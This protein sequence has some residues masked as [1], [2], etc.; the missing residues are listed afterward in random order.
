VRKTKEFLEIILFTVIIVLILSI[1]FAVVVTI[2]HI[3]EIHFMA[4][5][6]AILAVILAII[7][8]FKESDTEHK[9]KENQLYENQLNREIV[10]FL[11]AYYPGKFYHG[12]LTDDDWSLYSLLTNVLSGAAEFTAFYNEA[13][14]KK[15][16]E[17]LEE[18]QMTHTKLY[19]KLKENIEKQRD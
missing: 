6:V 4:I 7:R 17:G 12:K 9:H 14:S 18:L 8:E 16:A 5:I 10:Y 1:T 13:L 15:F 11:H 2:L 19:R 3:N